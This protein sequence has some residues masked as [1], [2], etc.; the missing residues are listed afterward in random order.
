M[1]YVADNTDRPGGPADLARQ[2]R[3]ALA[4]AFAN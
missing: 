1:G 2:A 3:E 4:A